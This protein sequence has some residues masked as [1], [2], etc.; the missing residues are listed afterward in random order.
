MATY[1][2]AGLQVQEAGL[3]D[4]IGNERTR[5]TV[6]PITFT[7]TAGLGT[8]YTTTQQ[9]TMWMNGFGAPRTGTSATNFT[10][11]AA[12]VLTGIIT[13]KNSNTASSTMTI[14]TAT[15]LVNAVNQVCSGVQVGDIIQCL[16]INST[17]SG[18]GGVITVAAG[19][20]GSFDANQTAPVIAVG[21]SRMLY[22]LFSNVTPGSYAYV[23]YT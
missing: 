6:S 18:A 2:N 10:A 16:V 15:N 17:S 21:A 14:D 22:I 12:D 7:G 20:G 5:A 23:V 3:D 4:V 8:A 9:G 1:Y 13:W 11:L 19:T